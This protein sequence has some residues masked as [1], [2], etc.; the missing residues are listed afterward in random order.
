M[1]V[2]YGRLAFI[3]NDGIPWIETL[4]SSSIECKP[5]GVLLKFYHKGTEKRKIK[6][7]SLLTTI[8]YEVKGRLSA[9]PYVNEDLIVARTQSLNNFQQN[10]LIKEIS[11]YRPKFLKISAVDI[12]PILAAA[13]KASIQ[14]C[15]TMY[16]MVK[17]ENDF[18]EYVKS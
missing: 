9:F 13:W 8:L 14:N 7:F 16:P 18:S 4:I 6:I 12:E 5:I 3:E 1:K 10:L 2:D 15:D 17:Q 11:F